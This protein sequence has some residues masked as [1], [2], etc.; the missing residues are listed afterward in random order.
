MNGFIFDYGW[1][2]KELKV[3]LDKVIEFEIVLDSYTE[4]DIITENQKDTYK[5]IEE[6]FETIMSKSLYAITNYYKAE[7]GDYKKESILEDVN[8]IDL[9]IFDSIEND[10]VIGLTFDCKW[11]IENGVGIKIKN[12]EVIDIGSQ[13]I[14]L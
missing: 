2:R 9:I 5:K 1:K 14:V 10:R 12:E 3:F 6:I 13:D 8:L 4:S 11:D 7:Y